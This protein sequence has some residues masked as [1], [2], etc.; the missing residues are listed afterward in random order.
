[1]PVNY[2]RDYPENWKTEI[3]PAIMKRAGE[4]RNDAGK[5][6]QEARCEKCG[7]VNHSVGYRDPAGA[8]ITWD[9]IENK[10]ERHG[11]DYFSNQLRHCIKENGSA[12]GPT[13]IVLTVA[14]LD[15]DS[16][17]KDVKLERLAALCQYDHLALDRPRHIEKRKTTLNI[18]KGIIDLFNGKSK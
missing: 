7:V 2:K 8:F 1:M 5:I 18:K 13:T 12:K 15:H 11:Y 17:N 10:L 16:E 14:H 4:I 6:I 3:R 9:E